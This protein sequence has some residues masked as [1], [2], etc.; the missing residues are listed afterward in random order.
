[1]Y[2]YNKRDYTNSNYVQLPKIGSDIKQTTIRR[3]RGCFKIALDTVLLPGIQLG[4]GWLIYDSTSTTEE[5]IN[6][7]SN[8]LESFATTVGVFFTKNTFKTEDRV[9]FY[10]I[11]NVGIDYAIVGDLIGEPGGTSGTNGRNRRLIFPYFTFGAGYS[12]K[13]G[14]GSFF[15]ISGDIGLKMLIANIKFSFIF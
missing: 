14:N 1:M 4:Y 15:R 2:S 11:W 8:T 7:H 10:G 9:G 13:I 3:A 12:M 5:F 6:I